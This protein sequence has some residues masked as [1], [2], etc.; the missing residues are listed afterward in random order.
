MIKTKDELVYYLKC[1]KVALMVPEN[2]KWPSLFDYVIM[3][4]NMR[5]H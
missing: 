4:G 1:D 3:F 2:K 5:L